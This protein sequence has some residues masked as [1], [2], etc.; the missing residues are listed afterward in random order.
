LA[1]KTKKM[2]TIILT[3]TAKDGVVTFSVSGKNYTYKID[4]AYHHWIVFHALHNPGRVLNFVK[5]RGELTQKE[6]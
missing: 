5:K 6:I 3:S 4:S 2:N 1:G